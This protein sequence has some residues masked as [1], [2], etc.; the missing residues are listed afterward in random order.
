MLEKVHLTKKICF[1]LK[2][3]AFEEASKVVN[4]NFLDT[5]MAVGIKTLRGTLPLV[6]SSIKAKAVV[7]HY[8]GYVLESISEAYVPSLYTVGQ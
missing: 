5:F 6:K 7:D 4:L 2:L 1:A 8:P 3:Q